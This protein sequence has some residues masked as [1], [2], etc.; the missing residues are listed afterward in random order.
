[1]P[2]DIECPLI[3]ALLQIGPD[4]TP[5]LIVE[6][7]KWPPRGDWHSPP[8]NRLAILMALASMNDPRARAPLEQ[9]ASEP[10]WCGEVAREG[11]RQLDEMK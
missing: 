6:L 4:A 1:M 7:H 3:K 8:F 11:V 9:A 2:V 10:G 5:A